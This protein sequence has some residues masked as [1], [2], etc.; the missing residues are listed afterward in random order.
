MLFY[1]QFLSSVLI[2]IHDFGQLN[3]VGILAGMWPCGILVMLSEL[4]SAES[5]SQVFASLHELLTD[6]DGI[7]SS[8]SK[9]GREFTDCC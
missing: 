4:F 2:Y 7:Q 3:S 8:L 5:K 1:I 9:Y 6:W